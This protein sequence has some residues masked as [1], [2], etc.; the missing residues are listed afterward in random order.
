[1][2]LHTSL[3]HDHNDDLKN[4]IAFHGNANKVDK[5]FNKN[6]TTQNHVDFIDDITKIDINQMKN[7]QK[8]TSQSYRSKK[9]LINNAKSRYNH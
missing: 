2:G 5:L 7:G 9:V 1:M 3:L 4:S 8:S 6:A